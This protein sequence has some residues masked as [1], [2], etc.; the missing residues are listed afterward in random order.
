MY[1][2]K[3]ELCTMPCVTAPPI[4]NIKKEKEKIASQL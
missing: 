2:N 1:V 3:D 4:A